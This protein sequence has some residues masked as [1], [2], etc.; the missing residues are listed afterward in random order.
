[1]VWN[2][3]TRKF[4][5]TTNRPI[6]FARYNPGRFSKTGSHARPGARAGA[7]IWIM[8]CISTRKFYE[9]LTDQSDSRWKTGH[10]NDFIIFQATPSQLATVYRS[11]IARDIYRSDPV[12]ARR[13]IDDRPDIPRPAASPWPAHARSAR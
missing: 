12:P 6:E 10:N 11:D 4:Y 3:C 5:E 8:E 9:T 13:G 7:M 1:M 2:A